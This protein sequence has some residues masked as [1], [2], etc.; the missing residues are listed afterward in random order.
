LSKDV[1]Q[2]ALGVDPDPF[3]APHDLADD[4]LA[5]RG[6][7]PVAQALQVRQQI[8]VD[9]P[10]DRAHRLE[11][12]RQPLRALGRGPVAPPVRLLQQRDVVNPDGL[13][14]LG[15]LLLAL[16]QDPQEQD[17]GQLGDVLQRPGTV[18]PAH[19]VADRLDRAV[20]R[21]RR[22]EAFARADRVWCH[23]RNH[24][25]RRSGEYEAIREVDFEPR[26]GGIR[27]PGATPRGPERHRFQ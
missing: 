27:E 16:V 20:D 25:D 24:R 4:L 23:G 2:V 9:E 14:L 15:L 13:G 12:Q 1:E 10:E 5:G 3:D 18:R 7:G 8:L 22:R 17:P 26:K 19:D 11:L 6:A 21:L